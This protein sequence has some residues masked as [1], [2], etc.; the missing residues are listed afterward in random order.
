MNTTLKTIIVGL[1]V[2][3]LLGWFLVDFADGN[4]LS[5]PGTGLTNAVGGNNT[6]ILI[7]SA[8][9]AAAPQDVSPQATL[10]AVLVPQADNRNMVPVSV[11][12]SGG[13]DTHYYAPLTH[14][15]QPAT[16]SSQQ[17]YD[18]NPAKVEACLQAAV[19]AGRQE[20]RGGGVSPDCA[21]IIQEIGVGR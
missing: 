18:R 12:T 3:A 2:L 14:T 1:G 8:P 4:V 10:P 13:V 19:A 6:T 9:T 15:P 7:I 11:E 17:T 16:Q 20:G 21:A 5:S